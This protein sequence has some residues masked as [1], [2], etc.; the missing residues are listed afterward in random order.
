MILQQVDLALDVGALLPKALRKT[1]RQAATKHRIYPN[2]TDQKAKCLILMERA[3]DLLLGVT[4][5]REYVEGAIR[6]RF[7]L[8]DLDK[9]C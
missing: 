6:V 8:L 1:G 9:Y 7:I 2:R 4:E 5:E 3:V